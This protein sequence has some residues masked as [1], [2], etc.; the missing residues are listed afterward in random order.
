M[1]AQDEKFFCYKDK[2]LV[3]CGNTIYYGS[4]MDDYV[5]V[6]Q[7]MDEKEKDGRK[8]PNRILVQLMRTDRDIKPTEMIVKKAEK[9]GLYNAM[10]VADI[11]LRRFLAA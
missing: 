2:P 7:I 9:T 6:L 1:Y 5:A 3:R 4:M 8:L 10:D 11:W